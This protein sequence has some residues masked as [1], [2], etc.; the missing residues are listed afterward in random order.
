MKK[1][2]LFL[3]LLLSIAAFSQQITG[4]QLLEKAIHF[5]DP[6]GNWKTFNG[7]LFV[8]MKTP[9]QIKRKSEIR[10]NLPKE[11]FYIKS[12]KDASTEEYTVNKGICSKVVG[13]NKNPSNDPKKTCKRANLYKDYYTFLYGLPMKLKDEGTIVHQK[14]VKKIFN[15]KEYWVLK[16]TYDENVGKDRWFFYFNPKNYEMEAYQF[17]KK[18]EN[19]GEFILLSGLEIIQE[20]KMPKTRDWYYNKDNRYLGTD[21][22]SIK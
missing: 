11:Y 3:F 12:Y 6:K 8:T 1:Q 19:S 17:F 10:I 9:D 2:V 15:G 18:E 4:N 7:E 22:L 16:V 20:I 5:H 21:L 13:G 14:V